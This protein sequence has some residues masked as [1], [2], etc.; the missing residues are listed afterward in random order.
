MIKFRLILAI[1]GTGL[2]VACVATGPQLTP[3]QQV[4]QQGLSDEGEACASYRQDYVRSFVAHVAAM[5]AGNDQQ[6]AAERTRLQALA[7]DETT[8]AQCTRPLCIIEPQQNGTL[9]SWCGYRFAD[10]SQDEVH[11][12]VEWQQ[13]EPRN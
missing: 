1:F 12:W 11:Q 8:T 7:A 9:T 2:L 10:T 5:S 6:Q 4:V 13:V 3:A